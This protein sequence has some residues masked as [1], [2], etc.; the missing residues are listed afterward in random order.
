MP[1]QQVWEPC[2]LLKTRNGFN[3]KNLKSVFLPPNLPPNFYLCFCR[4]EP[5]IKKNTNKCL[6]GTQVSPTL[7]TPIRNSISGLSHS[8][9]GAPTPVMMTTGVPGG[10]PPQA[11][12][13]LWNEA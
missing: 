2:R 9:P 3:I 13:L 4:F 11:R 6:L 8:M 1:W 12:T 10:R 5:V 7:P